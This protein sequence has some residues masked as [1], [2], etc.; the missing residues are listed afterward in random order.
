MGVRRIL[1]SAFA[2]PLF[3]G[4]AACGDDTSV[5]NPPVQSGPSSSP[6]QSAH[7]ESPEH[8]I[9]RFA[10]I[11]RRM[12]NTGEIGDYTRLAHRCRA[13]LDLAHQI[14]GFY[15]AGGYVRWEGWKILA[16]RPYASGGKAG[17][18]YSVKV[19]SAPT[20]YRESSNGP[21]K[22][23][24]GGLAMEIVTLDRAGDSWV[25][26]GRARMSS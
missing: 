26:I 7:R 25:V 23:L 9:R 20:V 5:A 13:C 12:E 19:R 2:A 10:G 3:L 8:F 24:N 11:E 6:T 15:R 4:I 1:A 22:N 16:I 18:A 17:R 21:I 14:H